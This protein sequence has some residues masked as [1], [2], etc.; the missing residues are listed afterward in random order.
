M[1]V[2]LVPESEVNT[3]AV[4]SGSPDE[5]GHDPRDVEGQLALRPLRH[6]PAGLSLRS[7][8]GVDHLSVSVIL[9][10]LRGRPLLHVSL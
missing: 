1:L 6:V 9:S 2:A 3:R 8:A 4:L 5:V 7:T 10:P